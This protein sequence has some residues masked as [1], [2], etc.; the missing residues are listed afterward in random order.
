MLIMEILVELMFMLAPL[1]AMDFTNAQVLQVTDAL[2]F[3]KYY[4]HPII[5][6]MKMV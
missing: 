4:I 6:V 3:H 5:Q 2:I 1:V